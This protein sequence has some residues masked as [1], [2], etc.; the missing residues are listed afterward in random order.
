MQSMKALCI[1]RPTKPLFKL[2]GGTSDG[3][4]VPH[5]LVVELGQRNS[6]H[7]VDEKSLRF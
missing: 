3:R 2:A 4:F 6:I 5:G 1:S 7:Q